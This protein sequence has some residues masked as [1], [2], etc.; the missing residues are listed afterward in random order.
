M[1]RC[2]LCH[3]TKGAHDTKC[4]FLVDD[5]DFTAAMT[6]WEAGNDD[7]RSGRPKIGDNP[8][9]LLGYRIGEAA[10]EEA[11]NGVPWTS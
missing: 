5:P 6:A 4:P 9:Y 3:F 10:A 7:G 1:D 11:E 8:Q 2:R